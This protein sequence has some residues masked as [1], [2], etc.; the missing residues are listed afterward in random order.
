MSLLSF[1]RLWGYHSAARRPRP[2]DDKKWVLA[3]RRRRPIVELLEERLP[4]GAFFNGLGLG[5][6]VNVLVGG[7]GRSFALQPVSVEG[8][9][10]IN[11]TLG[12]SGL[13]LRAV[14]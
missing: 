10:A 2:I 3:L 6:G 13:Q 5:A 9:V 12:L 8:S 11:V 14:Y 4:A 1:M 7:S